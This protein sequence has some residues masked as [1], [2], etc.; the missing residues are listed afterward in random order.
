VGSPLQAPS[1]SR[2][3]ISGY[4]GPPGDVTRSRQERSMT[5]VRRDRGNHYGGKGSKAMIVTIF[6]LWGGQDSRRA[7]K[8][9][10]LLPD[11]TGLGKQVEG[12]STVGKK[13]HLRA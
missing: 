9:C 4:V 13:K 1:R 11:F 3:W 2:V 12:P 8:R 10:A 6:L 7:R 5:G